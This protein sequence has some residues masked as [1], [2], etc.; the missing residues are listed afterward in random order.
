MDKQQQQMVPRDN[1]VFAATE[2]EIIVN[3]QHVLAPG[4]SMQQLP[5]WI[6]HLEK[7]LH[8]V[9]SNSVMLSNFG[10]YFDKTQRLFTERGLPHRASD[11]ALSIQSTNDRVLMGLDYATLLAIFGVGTCVGEVRIKYMGGSTSVRQSGMAV[12]RR[13]FL[14]TI[15]Y[16]RNQYKV[17]SEATVSFDSTDSTRK[18]VLIREWPGLDQALFAVRADIP[19]FES[20]LTPAMLPNTSEPFTSRLY[21]FSKVNG[22]RQVFE[23]EF[24]HHVSSMLPDTGT[25]L[26]RALIEGGYQGVDDFFQRIM[27]PNQYSISQ[28]DQHIDIPNSNRF[29]MN[30]PGHKGISGGPVF[31]I[32]VNGEVRLVGLFAGTVCVGGRMLCCGRRIT[33]EVVD[34]I[35]AY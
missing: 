29:S 18:V 5:D 21:N 17:G 27:K 3:S 33:Q 28:S 30:T 6:L 16:D 15:R 7:Q 10:L 23:R 9:G 19:G 34:V 26:V 2:G 14:T 12:G 1:S 13:L 25:D 24:A 31:E 11:G 35:N 32:G 20:H 22:T 8:L 4:A